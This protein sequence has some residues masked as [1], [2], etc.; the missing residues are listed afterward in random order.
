VGM[1]PLHG[2]SKIKQLQWKLTGLIDPEVG[3]GECPKVLLC[4]TLEVTASSISSSH[5]TRWTRAPVWIE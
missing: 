2:G 5:P 3:S 1:S 4:N